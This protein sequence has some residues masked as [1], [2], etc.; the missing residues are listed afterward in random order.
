M[1]RRVV[2]VGG[3]PQRVADA[4]PLD[5][6]KNV[7]DLELAAACRPIALGDRFDAPFAIGIVD[8]DQ[9]DRHVGGDH[10]PGR[11]RIHQFALEPRHLR[12]A[13][14]VGRRPVAFLQPFA[15]GAAIAA[16]IEHE[17]VE[18][19]SVRDPAVDASRFGLRKA[20]R[21]IF[22]E[23]AARP[24]GQQ[25]G[26]ALDVFLARV[27]GAGQRLARPPVVGDLVIVPLR[28]D[29]H[30]G[31]EREHVPVH[32]IVF[33]VA[34][35]LGERLRRLGLV[36]GDHVLPDLA[37]SHLHLGDDRAIGVNVVAAMDEEIRPVAQ[38]GGVGAHAAACLVDA[39]ALAGGIARPDERDG[40]PV[41]RR[42]AKPACHRLA[43]DGRG[44]KILEADAIEDVLPRGQAVDQSVGGEI[45]VGQRIDE[46]GAVDGLEA[47][48][49]R[50]LG[51][52]PC[53]AVGARPDHGGVVGYVAGL[54]AMGDERSI[55][56]PAEVRFG[57]AAGGGDRGR[58]RGGRQKPPPR[59]GDAHDH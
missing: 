18:Q 4:C 48:G 38:H 1:R 37:V 58:G 10:L 24:R 39:P 21:H 14:E 3:Q 46:Y 55:G 49:G 6:G 50:N 56:G 15:V 32:E 25:Q 12:G 27:L 57:D 59:H 52:H 13:E 40:A 43:D 41:G 29:R 31:I 44:R 53:R 54:D 42:A 36:L 7:R 20:H 51:Q 45:G 19:R 16:H 2:H 11:L 34:A 35:E 28:E 22:V 17:D 8:H 47:V 33:V 23:R 9:T 26:I 5:E 30:L